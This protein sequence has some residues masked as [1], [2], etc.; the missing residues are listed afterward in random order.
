MTEGRG[1]SRNGRGT[2]AERSRNGRRTVA[3]RSRSVAVLSR[4]HR[5][6]GT[7]W[8]ARCGAHGNHAACHVTAATAT[9]LAHVLEA[10]F[11]V[12][13]IRLIGIGVDPQLDEARHRVDDKVVLGG[14]AGRGA[15]VG[16]D[17]RRVR[18]SSLTMFEENRPR[19]VGIG[20]A[21]DVTVVTLM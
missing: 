16:R 8:G 4:V 5:L 11:L 9:H 20:P 18:V 1:R 14:R 3:E 10:V 15:V 12:L 21:S 2:V 17:E 13:E 6:R 19:Q 7:V